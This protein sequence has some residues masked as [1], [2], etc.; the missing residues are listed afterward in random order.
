QR[1]TRTRPAG[2]D[3]QEPP[4]APSA[5]GGFS[6]CGTRGRRWRP[7]SLSELR[8]GAQAE[9]LQQLPAIGLVHHPERFRGDAGDDGP[10]R[11]VM[12]DH[13]LRCDDGAHA[14]LHARRDA[15]ARSHDREAPDDRTFDPE[16]LEAE[17]LEIDVVV[18]DGRDA[19]ADKHVR[20]EDH[21]P[22]QDRPAAKPPS[23]PAR[24]VTLLPI[25]ASSPTLLSSARTTF[26]PTTLVTSNAVRTSCSSQPSA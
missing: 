4:T 20:L 21:S 25:V 7:C 17:A 6:R 16:W 3:R 13:G 18:V 19:G 26:A 22:G 8:V 9:V 12:G 15:G 24:S 14:D 1:R 23:T 11:Y 2:C 10:W 5:R